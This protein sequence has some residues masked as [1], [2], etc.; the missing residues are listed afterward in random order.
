MNHLQL[1]CT[2]YYGKLL[3]R[4]ETDLIIGGKIYVLTQ[5]FFLLVLQSVREHWLKLKD[6]PTIYRHLWELLSKILSYKSPNT[7][8]NTNHTE[9]TEGDLIYSFQQYLES[10]TFMPLRHAHPS[11]PILKCITRCNLTLC[12]QDK[13]HFLWSYRTWVDTYP[14]I[15][16]ALNELLDRRRATTRVFHPRRRPP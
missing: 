4:F 16:A 10:S 7:R 5:S 2:P 9:A 1:L 8:S 13:R 3:L 12:L 11:Y 15:I 6:N 14:C